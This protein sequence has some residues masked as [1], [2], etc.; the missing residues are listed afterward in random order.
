[1]GAEKHTREKTSKQGGC[2]VIWRLEL[3]RELC[4]VCQTYTHHSWANEK[5]EIVENYICVAAE[6]SCVLFCDMAAVGFF[7]WAA[8]VAR[9][10]KGKLILEGSH[11]IKSESARRGKFR[12]DV[13]PGSALM[14]DFDSFSCWLGKP[15]GDLGFY[16]LEDRLFCGAFFETR[17][18]DF[19]PVRNS[20]S[21][22][23]LGK[24]AELLVQTAHRSLVFSVFACSEVELEVEL[25]PRSRTSIAFCVLGVAVCALRL[26]NGFVF[27]PSGRSGVLSR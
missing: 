20:R 3:P 24:I 26:D 12:F 5:R 18:F 27:V 17:K 7:G 2:E 11:G 25:P 6:S 14:H 9:K 10:V 16:G 21:N 22:A 19:A 23:T 15:Q 4:C 8:G 1:M 13:S